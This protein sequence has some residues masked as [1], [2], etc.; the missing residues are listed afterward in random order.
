LF[1]NAEGKFFPQKILSIQQNQ[2]LNRKFNFFSENIIATKSSHS[3]IYSV[4]INGQVSKI[5]KKDICRILVKQKEKIKN[6]QV[7]KVIKFKKNAL[8]QIMIDN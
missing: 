4:G 2:L 3:N 1:F 7:Q 6:V 8:G 5:P